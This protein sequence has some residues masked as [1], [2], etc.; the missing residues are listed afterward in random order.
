M[1]LY[2]DSGRIYI[3]NSSG[4]ITF[5]TNKRMLHIQSTVS[6]SIVLPSIPTGTSTTSYNYTVATFP[7]S[8]SFFIGAMGGTSIKGYS[9]NGSIIGNFA[10][11]VSKSV[12]LSAMRVISFNLSGNNIICNMQVFN[13]SGIILPSITIPATFY[14][15]NYDL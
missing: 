3:T 14:G 6:S 9:L 10:V 1:S 8:C 4:D 12:S 5:D 7:V 15:G 2:A 11:T 13:N